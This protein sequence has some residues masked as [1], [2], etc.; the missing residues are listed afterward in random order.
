[1]GT[2][3]IEYVAT[4]NLGWYRCSVNTCGTEATHSSAVVDSF[5]LLFLYPVNTTGFHF[6]VQQRMPNK[7]ECSK[8]EISG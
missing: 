5:V 1:M 3:Y 7:D 8:S 4:C 6:V 2:T